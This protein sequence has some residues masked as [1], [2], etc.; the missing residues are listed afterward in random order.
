MV[1]NIFL[2]HLT[3]IFQ[4]GQNMLKP[5]T[6]HCHHFILMNSPLFSASW[7]PRTWSCRAPKAVV[8]GDTHGVIA[9]KM[10]LGMLV[11]MSLG[12]PWIP[13]DPWG[14]YESGGNPR[15]MIFHGRPISVGAD[16]REEDWHYFSYVQVS[17]LLYILSHMYIYIMMMM[18]MMMIMIIITIIIIALYLL[19]LYLL[20]LLLLKLSYLF[21][22]FLYFV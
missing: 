21:M 15:F 22:Y 17:E 11:P 12:D 2:T 4:D 5:P 18:M 19:L 8:Q 14:E 10:A 1:S 3:H 16:Q 20:L 13:M 6:N 7:N 9:S